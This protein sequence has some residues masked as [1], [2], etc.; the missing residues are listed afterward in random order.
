MDGRL[1]NEERQVDLGN[2]AEV[3]RIVEFLAKF[4]L[5]FEADVEYTATLFTLFGVTYLL[6]GLH[7]YL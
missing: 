1:E 7:S 4:D 5:G 3:K 6:P 2:P